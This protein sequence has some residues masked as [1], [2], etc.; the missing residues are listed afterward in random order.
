MPRLLLSFALTALC[1]SLTGD[2]DTLKQLVDRAPA[3]ATD[4]VHIAHQEA[5]VSALESAI[6]A[7]EDLLRVSSACTADDSYLSAGETS[8]Q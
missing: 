4:M 8:V 3:N 5:Y 6:E 2:I 7:A 1:K